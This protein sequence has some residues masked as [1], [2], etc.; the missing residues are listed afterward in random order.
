MFVAGGEGLQSAVVGAL[1]VG[2]V[3]IE[4][5][6]DA[7]FAAEGAEGEGDA[8][9]VVA[10]LE[11]LADVGFLA[12]DFVVAEGGLDGGGAVQAPTGG[13][14]FPDEVELEGGFGL[15]LGEVGVAE[16]A[17]VVLGLGFEDEG[18]G[19]EAVGDGSGLAAGVA[20]GGDRS[21]R[22]GAIGA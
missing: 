9:V 18:A 19:G 2:L 13:D 10:D 8:G 4:S 11:L 22:A 3:P 7:G 20:R 16:G 17:E 21:V 15:E 1:E 14:E 5:G 12:G 6:E